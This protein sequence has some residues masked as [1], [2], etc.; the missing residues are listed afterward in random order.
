MKILNT[1]I[2]LA[3]LVVIVG[4]SSQKAAT[5]DDNTDSKIKKTPSGLQYED[6][7]VGTVGD[8]PKKGQTLLVHYTGTLE[9]GKK[10]DSSVDRNQPFKMVYGETS[11]IQGWVEGLAT[12]K[13]GGKRKLII[14]PN[15]GYGTRGA[16]DLIPPNST[17]IFEVELLEIK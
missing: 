15:L 7:V 2:A 4:C 3:L 8:F 16:G 1:A 11:V 14:P 10:F 13:V 9:N 6:L 12:M 5:T 17:L